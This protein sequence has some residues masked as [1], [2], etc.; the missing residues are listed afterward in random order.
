MTRQFVSLSLVCALLAA[1]SLAL[2]SHAPA[3]AEAA[4]QPAI[5]ARLA[6]SMAGQGFAVTIE[7]HRYQSPVVLGVRGACRIGARDASAGAAMNAIFDQQFA[8]IGPLRYAYRGATY[9][10]LPRIR[11]FADRIVPRTLDRLGVRLARPVP[12]AFAG[13]AACPSGL[14]RLPDIRIRP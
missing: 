4:F 11:L 14:P 9:D 5:T 13:S 12:I 3:S 1:V 7:P 10:E 6:R 8:G 2:K